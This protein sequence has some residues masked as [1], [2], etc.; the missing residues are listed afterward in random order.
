MNRADI[1]Q[2]FEDYN[3]GDYEKTMKKYYTSDAVFESADYKLEG[4]D[5]IIKFMI[6][7][8]R[9]S[10]ETMKA[11]HVLVDDNVAAVEIEALVQVFEDKPNFHI[12]PLKKGDS[13]TLKM[14]AIYEI[15]DNKIDYVRLYRFTKWSSV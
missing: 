4:R 11:K 8:H 1:L 5:E 15:K 2:Y 6:E 10:T 13:I 12:K 3:T 9:G 14:I 7:S